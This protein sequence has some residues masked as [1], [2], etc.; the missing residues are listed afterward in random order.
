[1]TIKSHNIIALCVLALACTT[2]AFAQETEMPQQENYPQ[3]QQEPPQQQVVQQPVPQQYPQNP[4]QPVY[5]AVPQPTNNVQYIV[6]PQPQYQA[7]NQ[8]GYMPPSPT[9]ATGRRTTRHSQAGQGL[10]FHGG[11]HGLICFHLVFRK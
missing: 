2:A 8:Q 9:T 4:Q 11:Q 6:V 1:M 7:Q 10:L 3:D 5:Y